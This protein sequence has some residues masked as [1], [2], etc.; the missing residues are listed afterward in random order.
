MTLEFIQIVDDLAAEECASVLEGGLIDDDRG[1]FG[2]DAFHH[3][4]DAA[5]PEVVASGLHS[6]AVY[7]YHGVVLLRYIPTAVIFVCSGHFQYLAGDEVLSGTVALHYRCH[8]V[9]R[10]VGVVGQQLLGVFGQAVAAVSERGVVV[11]RSYAGVQSDALD[12]GLRIQPFYFRIG[13]QLVEVADPEGKVC[14]CE[15][16]N[17]LGFLEPHEQCGDVLLD[18]SVLQQGCEGM[19]CLFQCGYVRD[20]LYGLVLLRK[21]RF[22][23]ELRYSHYYAAG[24]QVVV[25]GLAFAQELRGEYQVEPF[26]PLFPVFHVQVA[27]VSHRNRG[28]D[29]HHRFRIDFQHQVYDLFY[30]A[31]VEVVLDRIVVGRCGDDYEFGVTVR[32]AAV[33]CSRQVQWLFGQVFFYVFVLYWGF[34]P[35]YQVYLFRYYVYGCH[36]VVLCQQSSK[37]K[38]DVACAGYG[39]A[40]WFHSIF[41]AIYSFKFHAQFKAMLPCVRR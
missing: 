5:L 14:V 31:C 18:R 16:L 28:L 30:M 7:A 21:F 26:Q 13:V 32:F 11:V 41:I 10:H 15:E 6:K 23:D 35:V 2:L 25:Q 9:L 22:V 1:A 20:G 24:I 8:H 39:Y 34:F 17:R 38:P 12:D 27:A 4:L 29:D 40:V 19:R 33:E 36:M 3:A 37:A